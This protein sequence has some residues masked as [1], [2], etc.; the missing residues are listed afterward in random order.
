VKPEHTNPLNLR[1]KCVSPTPIEINCDMGED[2]AIYR[3]GNDDAIAPHI[4]V[5]N[6]ACGFHGGGPAIM[7]RTVQ[8]AKA[9]RIKVGAH[10]SLPDREGFG[11]REIK[12]RPEDLRDCFIYQIGAL[13]GFLDLNGMPLSHVK[14]HGSIY[15]M[16]ARDEALADAMLDSAAAFGVPLY[17]IAGTHTHRLAV[18]RG[19]PHLTEYFADLEYNDDGGLVLA[20]AQWFDPVRAAARLDRALTTGMVE[21]V[22]GKLIPV[23]FDTVCVHLDTPN[24]VE[25]AKALNAVRS[26][27]GVA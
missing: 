3:L 24:V 1:S 11:R 23:T 14:P 27:R 4:Q 25:I 18:E 16:A 22:N 17:C 7:A 21:S 9:N 15:L 26:N 5:A 2:F 12:M 13:K 6:V 10:P 8:L 19:L 20:Q